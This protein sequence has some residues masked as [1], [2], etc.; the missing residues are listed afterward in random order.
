MGLFSETPVK[1]VK[2][3][4]ILEMWDD[5]LTPNRLAKNRGSLDGD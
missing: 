5:E 2:V 4:F 3:R 1:N